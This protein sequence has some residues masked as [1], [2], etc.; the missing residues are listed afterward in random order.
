MA[1]SHNIPHAASSVEEIVAL[2]DVT[3]VAISTPPFLH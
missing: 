2:P 1:S 3:G